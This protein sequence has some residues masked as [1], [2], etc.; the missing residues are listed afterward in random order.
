[1]LG[2]FLKNFSQVATA[3][4]YFPKWQLPKCAVSKAATSQVCPNPNARPPVFSSGSA[5]LPTH[6]S[7]SARPQFQP[8]APQKA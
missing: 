6:P 2:T 7:L 3:K 1:M 5:Q 4:G 8:G